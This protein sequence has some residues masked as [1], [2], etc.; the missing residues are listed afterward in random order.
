VLTSTATHCGRRLSSAGSA[1]QPPRRAAAH[2]SD[3][4]GAQRWATPEIRHAPQHSILLRLVDDFLFV[5]TDICAARR[6]VGTLHGEPGVSI[7]E[8]VHAD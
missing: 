7:L 1:S 8:S 5:S 4:D 3:D 6:F 2:S